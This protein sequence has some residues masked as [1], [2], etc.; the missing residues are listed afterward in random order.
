MSQFIRS[1]F[2]SCI[3]AASF[4]LSPGWA[5]PATPGAPYRPNRIL[6]KPR[7]GKDLSSF[8]AQHHNRLLK[9]VHGPDVEVLELGA[10]QHV[11]QMVQAYEQSGQ[12]EF[13]EPDYILYASSS[14]NDP[15]FTDGSLWALQNTGQS[16]GTA[17]ADI[18]AGTAWPVL[19]NASNVV[20]A[21]VD[22]G[23]RY[24]HE[25]LAA[26][27][28]TNPG[29]VAANGQD[30]DDDGYVDDVHG[31]NA[32]ERTGDPWDDV[33]HGT[34]VAGI[35]GGVGNNGK[36]V[37]GVAWNVQ[38]MACKFMDGSG[39]GA[40]SDAIVC[41]DYARTHGAHIINASWG[42]PGF[43]RSL[44]TAIRRAQ[45][46]GIIFVA[47]A[48][49][50]SQNLDRNPS[51]PASYKVNNMVVVAATTRADELADYSNYGAASV[52]LAAPG[53]D[54]L[55]TWFSSDRAY[56]VE[57]GTSMATP[58]VS[59]V[60]ALTKARYPNETYSQLIQHVTSGTDSLAVLA[61]KCL[62]GGRLN[63]RKA[64]GVESA[65]ALPIVRL[66]VLANDLSGSVRFGLMGD[67]GARYVIEE[68]SDL[69]SWTALYS[70]TASTD[71]SLTFTD[72]NAGRQAHQYFRARLVPLQ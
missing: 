66:A 44:Q 55:S 1:S 48:G 43:S 22:T 25:D 7:Q 18:G 30:D 5:G 31:I 46:A 71:G 36:G 58:Y 19:H 14:P 62:T 68:S 32:I 12:V 4:S 28:W 56:R 72:P 57:S 41:I 37:V 17:G 52:T 20:V 49:N 65:P 53:S 27:M 69:Q 39:E 45:A 15:K 38:L 35:I 9:R 3:L 40:T 8:H 64:L 54:I 50:E 33:G 67:P 21:V 61:G 42:G 60:L 70:R 10:D 51:Y 34:H 16:G 59:G 26:N 24:T 47:A 23:I 2:V 13:A 63:L 11:E 6:V 29:E